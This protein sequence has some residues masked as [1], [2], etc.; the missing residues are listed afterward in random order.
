VQDVAKTMRPPSPDLVRG[1]LAR[2]TDATR[3]ILEEFELD[4]YLFEVEARD[5][6]WRVILEC[7]TSEGA[8][9][10]LTV[11]APLDQLLACLDDAGARRKLASKWKKRL[12]ECKASRAKLPT[13]AARKNSRGR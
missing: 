4:T 7:A 5:G 2:A 8:W 6:V 9:Q 3:L 13:G 1:D 10:S 12:S 11:T